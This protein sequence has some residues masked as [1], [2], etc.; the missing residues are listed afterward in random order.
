MS[1]NIQKIYNAWKNSEKEEDRY[2]IGWLHWSTPLFNPTLERLSAYKA[3]RSLPENKRMQYAEFSSHLYDIF[4]LLSSEQLDFIE[5]NLPPYPYIAEMIWKERNVSEEEAKILSEK[6]PRN[7]LKARKLMKE[8]EKILEKYELISEEYRSILEKRRES[9]WKTLRKI[10]ALFYGTTSLELYLSTSNPLSPI[11]YLLSFPVPYQGL[12]YL[13]SKFPDRRI[14]RYIDKVLL[15]YWIA[16]SPSGMLL[17]TL[18]FSLGVPLISKAIEKCWYSDYFPD[19]L[20]KLIYKSQTFASALK[21][22]NF[23][24]REIRETLYNIKIDSPSIPQSSIERFKEE[25]DNEVIEIEDPRKVLLHPWSISWFRRKVVA[26]PEGSEIKIIDKEFVRKLAEKEGTFTKV[27]EEKVKKYPTRYLGFDLWE[28][29]IVFTRD[30][31]GVLP[32]QILDALAYKEGYTAILGKKADELL[33][34]RLLQEARK[35]NQSGREQF[36]LVK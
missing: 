18:E 17:S 22:E 10:L 9:D 34:S 5:R 15:F 33:K 30:I 7:P 8:K 14:R 24:E 1:K 25:I 12:K 21:T 11:I 4:F 19:F 32:C 29:R 13:S 36:Y 20:R 3:Y 31:I 2:L 27:M 26:I 23:D 35:M 16:R 28:G 6:I